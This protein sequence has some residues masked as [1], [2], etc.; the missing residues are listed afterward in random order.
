MLLRPTRLKPTVRHMRSIRSPTLPI[1]MIKTST[2][3]SRKALIS[4]ETKTQYERDD[5]GN[6][7][8]TINPDGT[9]TMARYNDKNMPLVQVDESNNV[10]INEYDN[11]GVNVLKK[12]QSTHTVSNAANLVKNDFDLSSLDYTDYAMTV[13]TYY[14]A[15]ET[16]EIAGLIR[17]ITDPKGT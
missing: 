8:K 16:A 3:R 6:V 15:S 12:Y 7:T 17:T 5:N 11:S 10:V 2:T 9:F 13:Y 4:W 14:P 1:R